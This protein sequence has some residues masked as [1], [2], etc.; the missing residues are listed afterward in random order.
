MLPS[1]LVAQ[2]FPGATVAVE[3]VSLIVRVTFA[4]TLPVYH[5][6]KYVFAVLVLVNWNTP[7][8]VL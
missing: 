6:W 8:V 7:G 5:I 1:E 3:P 2:L 4:G